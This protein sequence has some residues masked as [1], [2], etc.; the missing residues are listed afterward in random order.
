M[1]MAICSMGPLILPSL[2]THS[3]NKIC[4]TTVTSLC[5]LVTTQEAAG[6]R[7]RSFYLPVTIV[8]DGTLTD[9][10][11]HLRRWVEMKEF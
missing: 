9:S 1:I 4:M 2:D 7:L 8:H 11:G 3:F 5:Y 10:I 6:H